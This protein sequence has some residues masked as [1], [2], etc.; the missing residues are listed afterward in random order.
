MRLVLLALALA[1]SAAHAQM[2]DQ[3]TNGIFGEDSLVVGVKNILGGIVGADKIHKNCM[4]KFICKVSERT[5]G[6]AAQTE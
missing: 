4:Q 1:A 6:L 5:F 2:L 3:M